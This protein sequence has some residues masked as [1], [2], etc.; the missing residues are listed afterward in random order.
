MESENRKGGAAL[1]RR[2]EDKAAKPSYEHP[3]ASRSSTPG[4]KCSGQ[5]GGR[6]FTELHRP[7]QRGSTT[8]AEPRMEKHYS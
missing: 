5:G 8:L 2:E 6:C 4:K 1:Q 7:Q 3:R